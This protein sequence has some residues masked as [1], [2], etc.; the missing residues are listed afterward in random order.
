MLN[1]K[2]QTEKNH[3]RQ[4]MLKKISIAFYQMVSSKEFASEFYY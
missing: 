4:T 1:E 3:N 2:K